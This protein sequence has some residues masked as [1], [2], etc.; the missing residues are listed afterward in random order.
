MLF[1]VPLRNLSLRLLSLAAVLLLL[2]CGLGV[3]ALA[4]EA[5][6]PTGQASAAIV[7]EGDEMM[8]WPCGLLFEEPGFYA[9]GSGGEDLSDRVKIEGEVC[10]WKPGSYTLTYTACDDKGQSC[11]ALRTVNVLPVSLPETVQSEKTIYLSFDDGPCEYTEKL[12]DILDE[13]NAKATFFVICRENN[14]YMHLVQEIVARGHGLGIHSGDHDYGR[15][16]SSEKYFFEDFMKARQLIYDETGW[17]TNLFR[18]PGGSSTAYHMLGRKTEGGFDA[19]KQGFSDMGVRFYDWNVQTESN[20][21]TGNDMVYNFIRQ[22][23]QED[24]PVS[25]QHDT[26]LYSVNTVSRFLDWGIAN[27]YTFA[28]IDI[29]TPE[30]HAKTP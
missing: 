12:L 22:V 23:E 15:L 18:F 25:L 6:V 17:Y 3:C 28:A 1:A 10:S 11:E 30:I 13:Y 8:D 27:G 24:T 16:Y 21:A 9:T 2:V 14:P 7:L 19:I 5:H 26:R 20:S 29:S 4:E